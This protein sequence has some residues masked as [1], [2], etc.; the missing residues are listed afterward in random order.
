MPNISGFEFLDDIK[1]IPSYVNVPIVIVSGNSGQEF[2][3][4]AKNSNAAGVLTKPV[5]PETLI[6]IIEK[7]LVPKS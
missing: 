1:R 3:E 6:D 5:Q 4:K 2:F 7:N